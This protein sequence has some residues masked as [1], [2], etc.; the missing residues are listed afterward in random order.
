M[1]GTSM[2]SLSRLY[3][4]KQRHASKKTAPSGPPLFFSSAI[5][6]S[7]LAASLPCSSLR[8]SGPDC[9]A[10][11]LLVGLAAPTRLGSWQRATRSSR[12]VLVHRN[13]QPLLHRPATL[14]AESGKKAAEAPIMASRRRYWTSAVGAS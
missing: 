4:P 1:L 11:R 10:L 7:R 13:R 3:A 5:L 14:A 9:L 8:C 6:P 2:S 12:F